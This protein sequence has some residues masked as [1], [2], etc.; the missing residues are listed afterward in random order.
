MPSATAKPSK[1]TKLERETTLTFNELEPNAT[2]W[3]ASLREVH[4]WA[5]LG[6][7]ISPDGDG[8]RATVSKKRIKISKLRLVSSVNSQA[9]R[10]RLALARLRRGQKSQAPIASELTTPVEAR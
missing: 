2:L 9:A 3:T 8:W 7:V 6:L 1:R 10:E 4:R 5:A